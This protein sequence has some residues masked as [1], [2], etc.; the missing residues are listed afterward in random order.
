ME[1]ETASDYFNL[2][3]FSALESKYGKK[4]FTEPALTMD[5][6]V[7]ELTEWKN[8]KD[9]E[10]GN[11]PCHSQDNERHVQNV[12]KVGLLKT[13]FKRRHAHLIMTNDSREKFSINST[14]QDFVNLKHNSGAFRKKSS[15]RAKYFCDL[16]DCKFTRNILLE[17][18]KVKNHTV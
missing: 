10:I 15:S 1:Y 2:L 14:K 17:L 6:S 12:A 8:G 5:K 11:F 3:D 9:L 18:H 13:T 4:F 7:Q 16:C